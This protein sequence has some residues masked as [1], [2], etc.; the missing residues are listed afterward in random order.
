MNEIINPNQLSIDEHITKIKDCLERT[1]NSI[2]ETIVSIKECKDQLGDDVFQK[3]VSVKL[4]MS[5]ST[6]NRWISIGNSKFIMDHQKELPST[7][8]SLYTITQLEKKYIDHYPK[9]GYSKLEKMLEKGDINLTSQQTN[10]GDLL[11]VIDDRIKRKKKK[12]REDRILKLDDSSTTIDDDNLSNIPTLKELIESKTKFKTFVIDLPKELISKWG[13]DSVTEIDIMEEYPLYELRSPSTTEPINCLIKLPIN[14]LDVGI[15]VLNSFGFT[16]RDSYI[17]TNLNTSF[18]RSTKESIIIRGERGGPLSF[19]TI[20]K[21]P[22]DKIDDLVNYSKSN[23]HSP[24]L[25]VFNKTKEKDW[26]SVVL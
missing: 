5:P 16:Y 26:V 7:F 14:K 21:I 2:F 6:L 23:F 1:R 12:E 10:I 8:S 22:S 20:Q 13:N 17:P 15:K 18:V 25:L 11:K 19:D 24:Y 3:D 9:D 4:G